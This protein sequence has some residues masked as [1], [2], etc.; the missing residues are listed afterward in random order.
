MLF[1]IRPTQLLSSRYTTRLRPSNQSEGAFY[2]LDGDVSSTVTLTNL[3]TVSIN[4]LTSSP[5]WVLMS[6][7]TYNQFKC[8]RSLSHIKTRRRNLRSRMP[9]SR[10]GPIYYLT[11]VWWNQVIG[12]NTENNTPSVLT[13]TVLHKPQTT[14]VSHG[15]VSVWT[16]RWRPISG[17]VQVDTS[18]GTT[19]NDR[20]GRRWTLVRDV[21]PRVLRSQWG[22]RKGF[23]L[24]EYFLNGNY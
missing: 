21:V 8:V 1:Y 14:T 23:L 10:S 13:P 15:Q 5:W 4:H 18:S 19:G 7:G 20:V 6:L 17:W 22:R 2:S 16:N 9:L 11:K 3:N 24:V 12:F